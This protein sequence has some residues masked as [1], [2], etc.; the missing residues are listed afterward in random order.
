MSAIF[1]SSQTGICGYRSSPMDRLCRGGGGYHAEGVWVSGVC[2]FISRLLTTRD[3]AD[4]TEAV[5]LN[6][7]WLVVWN[8]TVIFPYIGNIR[9]HPKWLSYFSEG[10]VCHQPVFIVFVLH[11][12][13]ILVLHGWKIGH[14]LRPSTG[15]YRQWIQMYNKYEIYRVYIYIHIYYWLIYG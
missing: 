8:M 14:F 3:F 15:T 2:L 13:P 9:Y 7:F 1:T 6:L 10:W 5:T 11:V 4:V 12:V